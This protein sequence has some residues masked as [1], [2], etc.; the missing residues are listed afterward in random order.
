MRS[1]CP[2]V[3]KRRQA[4][5]TSTEAL[6]AAAAEGLVLQTANTLSGYKNVTFDRRCGPSNDGKNHTGNKPYSAKKSG[7]YGVGNHLGSF[8]TA[9]E[10]ALHVARFKRARSQHEN[11]RVHVLY[12]PGERDTY[13]WV[14]EFAFVADVHR[15]AAELDL[16]AAH[17]LTLNQVNYLK[18]KL[19]L[20]GAAAAARKGVP[21]SAPVSGAVPSTHSRM[22][23]LETSSVAVGSGNRDQR[24]GGRDE[25]EIDEQESCTEDPQASYLSDAAASSQED[26]QVVEAS[27]VAVA[28]AVSIGE[29]NLNGMTLEQYQMRISVLEMKIAAA[30]RIGN[31][32]V[33]AQLEQQLI[34]M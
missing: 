8:V 4:S 23:A 16:C 19:G 14:D 17:N 28:P 29:S 12:S 13:A 3:I 6:A 10:A 26:V 33:V 5:L 25:D 32:A 2:S 24:S 31:M 1:S 18:R 11:E 20:Y 22:H 9:E 34:D 15:G 30:K 27:A 7:S 21:I